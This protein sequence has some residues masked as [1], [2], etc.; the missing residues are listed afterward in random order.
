M[1]GKKSITNKLNLTRP[2]GIF[3]RSI[4]VSNHHLPIML[5]YRKE[6]FLHKLEQ[7]LLPHQF[8]KKFFLINIHRR[9]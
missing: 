4:W 2:A 5:T 9:K 6:V 8:F 3:L 1:A 7:W